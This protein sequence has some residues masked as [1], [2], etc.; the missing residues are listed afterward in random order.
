[1]QAVFTLH[2]LAHSHAAE[3]TGGTRILT[4]LLTQRP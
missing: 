2:Q 1:M 3:V 4:N